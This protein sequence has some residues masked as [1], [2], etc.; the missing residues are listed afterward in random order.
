MHFSAPFYEDGAFFT[1]QSGTALLDKFTHCML[2]KCPVETLE[3]LLTTFSLRL[4]NPVSEARR[5]AKVVARRYKKY[6]SPDF[7]GRFV[8]S[9]LY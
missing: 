3:V 4:S 7:G 9:G 5:D 8:L 6:A 2:T 1:N